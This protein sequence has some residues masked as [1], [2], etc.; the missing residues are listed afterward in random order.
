MKKSII[1]LVLLCYCFCSW[2]GQEGVGT[3]KKQWKEPFL[4]GY[5]GDF[6]KRSPISGV[7][8]FL[9][10]TSLRTTAD[11]NGQFHFEG[12][13]PGS[14][15]FRFTHPEYRTLIHKNRQILKEGGGYFSFTMKSGKESD[16]P[17]VFDDKPKGQFV[18]DEDAE[19][20][21]QREPVYPMTALKEKVEG[22]VVL[23]VG[24]GEEGEALYAGFK[25]G[26]N[27]KDLIEASMEAIQ[28][29]KFKPAK[30][31]GKPVEVMVTVPFNFKLADKSTEFPLNQVKGPLTNDDIVSALD[32]LGIQTYR[33]SYE[34]PF[35]HRVSYSLER[36]IDGKRANFE[37]TGY[38]ATEPGKCNIT[39]FKYIKADSV[40]FT[41]RLVT[42]GY[43]RVFNF[44]RY[45]VG[46]YPSS[47]WMP[48][49][50][51]H[52]QS[53]KKVPVCAY[54][55]SQGALGVKPDESLESIVAKNKLVFVISAELVLE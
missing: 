34:I 42:G 17:L 6:V 43:I 33:F 4:A 31:K 15:T 13:T 46:G 40:L 12:L 20:L 53:H 50:N 52:I 30:V 18:I 23:W 2:A 25:E 44:S 24:V 22:T 11:A 48:F 49:L 9:E 45:P 37:N 41:L 10:G 32:Y 55:L 26:L 36:Y 47:S 8:V 27:R 16:P 29:F 38:G 5:V 3:V 51:L 54:V 35:K 39:L 1:A 19:I 21:E 14:Y 7:S 28:Y